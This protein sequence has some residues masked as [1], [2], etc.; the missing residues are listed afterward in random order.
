M[1][2]W[3]YVLMD[4]IIAHVDKNIVPVC[5]DFMCLNVSAGRSEG[6]MS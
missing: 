3:L 1:L 2:T 4:E 6:T 5:T